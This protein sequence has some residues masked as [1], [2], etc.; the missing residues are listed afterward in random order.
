MALALRVLTF[1]SSTCE[2]VSN[3][4]WDGEVS[5]KTQKREHRKKAE[6]LWQTLA[7]SG[8][9][10]ARKVWTHPF[11]PTLTPLTPALHLHAAHPCAPWSLA[12]E[13]CL[14]EALS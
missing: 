3:L 6:V 2:Q 12:N 4:F 14:Y 5:Q 9:P 10:L 11:W 13:G 7:G 8:L 1:S